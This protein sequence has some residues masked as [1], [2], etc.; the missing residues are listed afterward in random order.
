MQICSWY[1]EGKEQTDEHRKGGNTA[2]KTF[3]FS[4]LSFKFS[5]RRNCAINVN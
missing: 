1:A 3:N 5:L 2:S 4:I